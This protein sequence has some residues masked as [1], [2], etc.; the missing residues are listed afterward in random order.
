MIAKRV[1]CPKCFRDMQFE[2]ST[3]ISPVTVEYVYACKC[4]KMQCVI[5]WNWLDECI[6]KI[7][8]R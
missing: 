2:R 6:E 3:E 8:W 1:V 4:G 5:V 7:D